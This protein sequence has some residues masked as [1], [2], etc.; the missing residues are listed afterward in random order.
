M[1]EIKYDQIKE[2][3]LMIGTQGDG[4]KDHIVKFEDGKAVRYSENFMYHQNEVKEL[5]LTKEEFIDKL[6]A[7][8]IE[9]WDESYVLF[10]IVDGYS[11]EL[12]F[13]YENGED[14]FIR[15]GANKYPNNIE[16][17]YKLMDI[18]FHFELLD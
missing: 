1:Q 4:Y 13:I 7:I 11:W 18:E 10:D 3:A 8:N 5:G 17:L 12:N 14:T 9:K 2:V 6:Q 16:E 15:K